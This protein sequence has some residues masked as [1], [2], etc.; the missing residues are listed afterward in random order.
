MNPNQ[1]IT[2]TALGTRQSLWG[3]GPIWWKNALYYVDIEGK[4]IVRLNP[5]SGDERV[6]QLDQRI[7]CIAPCSDGHLLYAGDRGIARF[8]LETE[9]SVA[10]CDPAI[11]PDNR[12]NDG[13]CDPWTLLGG[14]NQYKKNNGDGCLFIVW[15]PIKELH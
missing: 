3:E 11:C 10:L 6:W 15:N 12:F 8:N 1:D 5:Q 9:V 7:G 14:N 13:K 4:A 2:I